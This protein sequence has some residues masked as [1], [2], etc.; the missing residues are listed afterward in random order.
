MQTESEINLKQFDM[1]YSSLGELHKRFTGGTAACAGFILLGV[2]W[3]ANTKDS[4]P[5]LRQSPHFLWIVA[6][7]P[8]LGAFLYSYC[9]WLV[10]ERSQKIAASLDGF[11]LMS[12]EVY[13]TTAISR[14]QFFVFSAA[15]LLL[16]MILGGC[17]YCAGK[18]APD[19]EDTNED[20]VILQ[21]S[22]PHTE[23]QLLS[24]HLQLYN[25]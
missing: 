16:S 6:L 9:A 25:L 18:S 24:P 13:E 22:Q 7:A 21:V 15:I 12:R 8:V 2:V 3:F 17:I 20:E 10:H 23:T 5:F 11:Y 4:A 1:L 19:E 14:N